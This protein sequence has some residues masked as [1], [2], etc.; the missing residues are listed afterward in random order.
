MQK[1]MSA[2]LKMIGIAQAIKI[3]ILMGELDSS[4]ISLGEFLL[5]LIL[6]F[7]ILFV[8]LEILSIRRENRIR[9]ENRYDR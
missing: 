2:I 5:R 6:P 7:V 4:L 3:L 9:K 1:L 8:D